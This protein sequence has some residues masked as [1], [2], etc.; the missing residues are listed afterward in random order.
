MFLN[1]PELW[2]K[3]KSRNNRQC[4]RRMSVNYSFFPFHS[5]FCFPPSLYLLNFTLPSHVLSWVSLVGS[6]KFRSVLAE[7]HNIFYLQNC[8]NAR[9]K[10]R[11]IFESQGRAELRGTLMIITPEIFARTYEGIKLISKEVWIKYNTVKREVG[12]I[13]RPRSV[14]QKGQSE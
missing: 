6:T 12:R 13:N 11:L 7:W 8:A 4:L 10:S 2:E 1:Y 9:N 14:L 5:I 3:W